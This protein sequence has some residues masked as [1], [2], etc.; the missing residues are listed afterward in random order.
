MSLFAELKRR[1]VIRMAGLYLVGAWLVVQV[2]ETVLPAFDVPNWVLRATIILL[3]LGFVPALVF[4]WVFELTPQGLKRDEEI[5]PAQSMAPRTARRMDRILLAVSVL[6]IAYFVFDKFVLAP[7][8]EAELVTQA[9]EQVSAAA[10]AKESTVRPNSIAVLPFANMSGDAAN[11]YF[12][13]GISEEILNVL[14]GVPELQVAARTSSFSFKGKAMEVPEIARSLKVRMILEGSVRQ[15]GDT[16]RITAQLIDAESGFHRWSQ[17]YDRKLQDIFAIQDEIAK[18]I[19]DELKVT[20][21]GPAAGGNSTGTK[22]VEAYDLYLRGMAA[23]HRRLDKNLWEA[24]ELFDQALALDPEFTQ[25][26][27][28]QALTYSVLPAYSERI[29]WD[30]A[31]ARANDLALRALALDPN[32]P[33]P[34]AAL[35]AT[36]STNRHDATAIALLHRAISLRPSFATAHHWLGVALLN[37]GRIDEAVATLEHAAQLDPRSPA[38]A[39]NLAFTL[40]AADRSGEAR[41][42][43]EQ[44]LSYATDY[45]ACLQYV[46]TVD[47][48]AGKLDAARPLLERM[49]AVLNP[50]ASAQGQEITD[51]LAG[52]SDRHALAQRMAALPFNSCLIDTSGNTLE[53]QIVAAVLMM[54]GEHELALDY[55]ERNVDNLGSSMNWAVML[56]SMDPI[57][58]EPRFVAIIAKLRTTDPYLAR[59]CSGKQ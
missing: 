22:S 18:A 55:M 8:R 15:Q 51:A 21:G 16:V 25:A 52:R 7:Q 57:R 54:L 19:G 17:T 34:L 49:A 43:C 23:W 35:A 56:P 12:S 59:A 6:A 3:A 48:M 44:A 53:D 40:L 1:N 37:S 38:I 30:D 2:A 13:D 9:T 4:A 31:L 42:V 29:A 36:S 41:A 27:A 45:P 10:D 50:G 24:I 33:E 58:C 14:A 11:D 26:Y 28:G 5:D 46:A 39:D 47:L 20:V 32:L